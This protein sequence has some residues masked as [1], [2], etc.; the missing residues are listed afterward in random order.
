MKKI[1]FIFVLTITLA[2]VACQKHQDDKPIIPKEK[3]SSGLV[4]GEV[5]IMSF[6]IRGYTNEEDVRNMWSMRAGAVREM[7][8]DQKASIIGLQECSDGTEW[9][10]VAGVMTPRGYA[11][12]SSD[13][14]QNS[15]LYLEA[16]LELVET[17]VFWQSDS[18]DKASEC[19]DGYAR[20]VRWA[21]FRIKATGSSF[22]YVDT[23]LGL[24]PESR[25]KAMTLIQRRISTYNV[26]N[27]PVVLTA[28][29]NTVSEDSVFDTIKTTMVNARDV[30]A[31][32]DRLNTYNAWGNEQKAGII[33]HI[34]LSNTLSPSIYMTVTK[35][36][37][38]HKL[39]SDHYPVYTIVKF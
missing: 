10:Y 12:L 1:S 37:D 9:P 6:N 21:V 32:T 20:I 16:E 39:V 4:P 30:A 26:E 18:P 11:C 35:Q 3:I 15:I 25:I 29:C 5:K 38:G 2:S 17:G 14:T 27:L 34:W 31:I 23:H 22:F 13:D 33:D 24:T 7:F 19:W 28:D 36:Y 8:Y